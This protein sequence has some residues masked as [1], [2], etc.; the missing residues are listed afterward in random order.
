MDQ[1]IDTIKGAL[2][3]DA[4]AEQKTAAAQACRAL[5]GAFEAKPGEPI[6]ASA[7]PTPPPP[8]APIE[9]LGQ[10]SPD[11][12]LDLLLAKL[13]TAVPEA[14]KPQRSGFKVQLVPVPRK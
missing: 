8:A 4:T 9:F 2:G 10:L 6:A 12:A 1:L 3:D 7:P 13:R 5:L 11:Q 14:P